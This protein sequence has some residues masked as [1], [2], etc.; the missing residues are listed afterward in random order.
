[1]K[2]LLFATTL[3]APL[4]FALPAFADDADMPSSYGHH[5]FAE[6]APAP[7]AVMPVSHR[8]HMRHEVEM[9]GE[10]WIDHSLIDREEVPSSAFVA[11]GR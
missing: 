11:N 8:R 4:A 7:V 9:S 3:L 2:K 5:F 1:M 6:P 10:T